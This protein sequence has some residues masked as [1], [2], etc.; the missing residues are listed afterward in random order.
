MRLIVSRNP[1]LESRRGNL[2][3]VASLQTRLT[4]RDEEAQQDRDYRKDLPNTQE[5]KFCKKYQI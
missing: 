5:G 3:R 2:G 1:R 4:P